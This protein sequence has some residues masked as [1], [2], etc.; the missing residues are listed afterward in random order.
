MTGSKRDKAEPR[1][2]TRIAGSILQLHRTKLG[3]SQGEAAE[4][5]GC[6]TTAWSRAEGGISRLRFFRTRIGPIAAKLHIDAD[7]LLLLLNGLWIDELLAAVRAASTS[8]VAHRSSATFPML[9]WLWYD[10]HARTWLKLLLMKDPSPWLDEWPG[11]ALVPCLARH[12]ALKQFVRRN[13]RRIDAPRS[14]KGGAARETLWDALGDPL[15]IDSTSLYMLRQAVFGAQFDAIETL[16]Q[17]AG[18]SPAVGDMLLLFADVAES[19]KAAAGH[20]KKGLRS[21]SDDSLHPIDRRYRARALY[22]LGDRRPL[23]TVVES[24]FAAPER[25]VLRYY[26]ER[27]GADDR[28]GT[29]TLA[30]LCSKL[31]FAFNRHSIPLLALYLGTTLQLVRRLMTEHGWSPP[32]GNL[33]TSIRLDALLE[34]VTKWFDD[35]KNG[36]RRR[37]VRHDCGDVSP[38]CFQRASTAAE[39]IQTAIARARAALRAADDEERLRAGTIT[40]AGAAAAAPLRSGRP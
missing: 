29:Q 19:D 17:P 36:R 27:S 24:T 5:V 9:Q 14:P 12:P 40:A 8:R 1:G 34:L 26:R 2:L 32:L 28:D 25:S 13:L 22:L 31:E 7:S 18:E 11:L 33:S 4:D 38:G 23:C 21:L 35:V 15:M 30:D 10:A 20:L 3:L 16:R 37:P 6:S 39:E